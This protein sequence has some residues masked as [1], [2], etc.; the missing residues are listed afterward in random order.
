MPSPIGFFDSGYGGLTVLKDVLGALPQYDYLYLGDNARAPYGERSSEEIYAYTRNALEYLF[1]CGCPL[2]ILACFTVSAVAL[3]RLQREW[4]PTR[5]PN[6]VRRILGVIAPVVEEI[7]LAANTKTL[8]IAAT[9]AMIRSGAFGRE[10][11]SRG[12]REIERIEAAC[13]RVV[14]LIE[15]DIRDEARLREQLT[16]CLAPLRAKKPDALLLGC[17]HYPLVAGQF[18]AALGPEVNLLCAGPMV[19]RSL[20]IYLQRHRQLAAQISV[21]GTRAYCTSGDP[22]AFRN[23]AARVLHGASRIMTVEHWKGV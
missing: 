10:L 13:P 12:G 23:F 4:L 8:G 15:A 16:A 5:D 18:R 21:G 9:P 1:A 6:G 11:V 20:E 14:S 7:V 22:K 3:R 2:V 19:A 17:T